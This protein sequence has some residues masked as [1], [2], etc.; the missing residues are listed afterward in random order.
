M[1]NVFGYDRDAFRTLLLLPAEGR[2]ILLAKNLAFLPV[3]LSVGSVLLLAAAVLLRLPPWT[4]LAAV[5]QLLAAYFILCVPANFAATRVP[6]RLAGG[7][8]RRPH[9]TT[10]VMIAMFVLQLTVPLTILVVAI[11]PVTGALLAFWNPLA[12][13]LL[14]VVGSVVVLLISLGVYGAILPAAGDYFHTRSFDILH[15]ATT[16]LA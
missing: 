7:T 3:P 14:N 16:E 15:A 12:G 13:T 8:M 9:V 5:C 2:R 10:Q 1:F 4:F 11:P 6:Y